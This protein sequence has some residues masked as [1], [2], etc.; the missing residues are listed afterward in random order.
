MPLAL[1]TGATSGIGRAFAERLA[2]DGHDLILVAR[3][4]EALEALAAALRRQANVSVHTLAAD[5]STLDGC[6]R[7]E[8]HL[9]AVDL[10]VNNAGTMPAGAFLRNGVEAEEQMLDLNTRAVLRLTHA[11]LPGMIE[12]R[13]GRVVNVASFSALGPGGLATTYPASKSWVLAFTEAIG[14]SDQVRRS[15]VRMMALLPGFTRTGLFR[16]TGIET[17]PMPRWIWPEADRVVADA[18]RDLAKGR[19]VCVPSLRYKLAVWGLRHLPRPMLKPLSWDFSAPGKRW[20][21]TAGG[22]R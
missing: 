14:G 19:V 8:E 18:L 7:V 5:L 15:G 2:R 17:S 20:P 3:T 22:G 4:P 21:P 10:L 16:R 13:S 1:V 12:R 9:G 6:R 11:V